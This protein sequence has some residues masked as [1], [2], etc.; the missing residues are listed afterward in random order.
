MGA[1]FT[2]FRQVSPTGHGTE[3]GT[4]SCSSEQAAH[5]VEA[6]LCQ[7]VGDVP[8]ERGMLAVLPTSCN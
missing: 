2:V 6:Y 4:L 3:K 8:W 1:E 5:R 7:A